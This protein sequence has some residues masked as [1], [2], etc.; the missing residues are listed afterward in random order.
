MTKTLILLNR[1]IPMLSLKS[2]LLNRH[3]YVT[4]NETSATKTAE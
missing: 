2:I 4:T 1:L 3:P